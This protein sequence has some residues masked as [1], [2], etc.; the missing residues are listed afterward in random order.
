MRVLPRTVCG[1]RLLAVTAWMVLCA[2]AWWVLPIQPR[3]TWRLPESGRPVGF[4][5]GGQVLITSGF[6]PIINGPY[7]YKGPFRL[8][9]VAT[10]RQIESYLSAKDTFRNCDV[11]RTGRWLAL[12]EFRRTVRLLDLKD[13]SFASPRGAAEDVVSNPGFFGPDDRWLGFWARGRW[14]RFSVPDLE[15][16]GE[17]TDR[18]VPFDALAPDGR[19][20]SAGDTDDRSLVRVWDTVT[21]RQIGGVRLPNDWWEASGRLSAGGIVLAAETMTEGRGWELTCWDVP[22]GRQLVH[23]AGRWWTALTPSGDALVGLRVLDNLP[24]GVSELVAWDLP[25]GTKRT[26]RSS[27]TTERYDYAFDEFMSP[28][29]RTA[30]ITTSHDRFRNIRAIV[31]RVGLSWPFSAG[32]L[33]AA[34]LFAIHTGES[35]GFVAGQ[36]FVWSQ[37]GARLAAVGPSDD[38][39]VLV[40][41]V[42]PRKL[43]T[44]FAAAAGLLALPVSLVAFWRARRLRGAR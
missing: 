21:G 12:A 18:V 41:D 42:P 2:A 19:A 37:D 1:T 10:G 26:I 6:S 14:R 40:W 9:D 3:A 31:E 28:D 43:L 35:L 25:V 4:L 7:E 38:Q 23:D 20:L 15:P 39:T 36:E 22:T 29:G 11:S 27:P 24:G 32:E 30:L 16:L 34:E 8:W 33:P 13:G 44:W 17:I 5:P